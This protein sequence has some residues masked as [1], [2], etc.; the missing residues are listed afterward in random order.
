[1]YSLQTKA[2]WGPQ[3]IAKLVNISNF[4]LVYDTQITIVFMESFL[5]QLQYIIVK[6]LSYSLNL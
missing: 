1:M 3:T 6:T 4:T 2:K 5:I